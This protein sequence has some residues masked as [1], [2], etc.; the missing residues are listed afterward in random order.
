MTNNNLYLSLALYII[1][2]CPLHALSI[3]TH[4]MCVTLCRVLFFGWSN[5]CSVYA[6]WAIARSFQFMLWDAIHSFVN[7]KLFILFTAGLIKTKGCSFQIISNE[8]CCYMEICMVILW[9]HLF[10]AKKNCLTIE[11]EYRIIIRLM[12]I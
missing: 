3:Q 9:E 12:M 11:M 2:F 6:T 4:C 7:R 5:I 1:H 10:S 8:C